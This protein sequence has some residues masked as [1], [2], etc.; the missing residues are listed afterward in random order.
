MSLKALREIVRMYLKLGLGYGVKHSYS[1]FG[2]D[3]I[4]A[5]LL[6][7]RKGVYVDVGAFH[8]VQYSNTYALYRRG[9]HGLV[10]DPSPMSEILFRILRPR[11]TFVR[12]AVGP[13]GEGIYHSFSDG[14][15]NTLS[16]DKADK[17]KEKL[18]AAKLSS[19]TVVIRPLAAILAEHN[20]M[21][22]DFLSVDAEG[23]DRAVLE[24]HDWKILPRVIAVEDDGF[25]TDRAAE[26]A[27]YQLLR[28]K[29]Y[30]MV[31]LSG[32]TCV[33]SYVEK[34]SV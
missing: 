19:T 9:W 16:S 10:I 33:Y 14:A 28:S 6:R 21:R 32:P 34:N 2:E 17:V 11:D 15:Y 12:C 18:S 30:H 29:G 22:I 26:S 5:A 31:G 27:I 24:S 13:Y 7:S 1:Q 20:I 25:D 8:P 4:V 3:S 23:M